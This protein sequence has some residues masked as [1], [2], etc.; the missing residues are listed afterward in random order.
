MLFSILH[1]PYGEDGTARPAE[2]GKSSV[3]WCGLLVH[4]WHDK[5]VMKRLLKTDNIP[6]AI[7][8]YLIMAIAIRFHLMK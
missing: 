1:G 4:S 2:A 8:L 5:D 3:C 6:I 7:F